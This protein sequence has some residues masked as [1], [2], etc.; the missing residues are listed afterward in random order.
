[1]FVCGYQ[2][3]FAESKVRVD[4]LIPYGLGEPSDP[5]NAVWLCAFHYR[6]KGA[7]FHVL[8][9]SSASARWLARLLERVANLRRRAE[10]GGS[11]KP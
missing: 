6:A 9:R 1:M 2:C 5:D 3:P 10:R 8:D 11:L 4:H 7:E